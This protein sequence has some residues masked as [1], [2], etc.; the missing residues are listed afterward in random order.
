[1]RSLLLAAVLVSA[2]AWA[3]PVV[4][5]CPVLPADN[6]WNVPVDTLPVDA[7][8]SAYVTS[9]GANTSFHADFGA[10]LYQG[11]AIGI[12]FVTVPGTQAK[13]PITF[14]AYGDES[15]PGPYPVP[16][17]APVEGAPS[18][19]GD[20]HVLVVDK[21]ACKLYE[22]Y[23]AF[24][25]TNNS[26]KADQ[27]SVYDL[28]SHALRPDGWTSADAAGLPIFPGLAR[29]EEV[30]A[31]EI[32]HALRFTVPNT[33]KAYVWPARHYASSSTNVNLPPMG[34]RFRLKAG[35]VDISTFSPQGQVI[36]RALQKYGMILADNGS[37]WYISGIPNAGWNNSALNSDFGRLKGSFFEAVDV[38]SLKID[39]DSGQAV[40]G[41]DPPPPPPPPS[42][43]QLT[44]PNGGEVLKVGQAFNVTWTSS[45]FTGN[46]KIEIS[47]DGGVTW[48]VKTASTPNDGKQ[49]LTFSKPTT[50]RGRLRITSIAQPQLTDTSN[51]DF[52][53]Q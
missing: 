25:Q 42:S 41:D 27:G 52:K 31:G 4:D 51:G 3:Q 18:T 14:T 29:Y 11:S 30:A 44:S 10:G 2:P 16:P 34:Q 40:V 21:G 36:L 12:P 20:R 46:I 38:S 1:M 19:S 26:W 15:D 24:K 47:K 35:A 6:I 32:T 28:N 13:V 33:R 8:S 49:S 48:K 39:D 43:I 17:T 53:I 45:G 23:R 22:L 7:K 50:T 37:A 9:I 5:G